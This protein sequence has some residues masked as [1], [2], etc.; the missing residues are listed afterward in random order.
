M[1]YFFFHKPNDRL[2]GGGIIIMFPGGSF[3]ECFLISIVRHENSIGAEISSVQL[4]TVLMAC[5]AYPHHCMMIECAASACLIL[6]MPSAIPRMQNG[7]EM[8]MKWKRN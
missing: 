4:F 2:E 8:E 3:A 7:N 6:H 5:R 1:H